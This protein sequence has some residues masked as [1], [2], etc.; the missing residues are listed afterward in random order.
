MKTDHRAMSRVPRTDR[1]GVPARRW[2]FPLAPFALAAT[3]I[4]VASSPS[5]AQSAIS[6]DGV[7]ESRA[8]GFR[9]PDGSVQTS[10]VSSGFAPVAETGQDL[11]YDPSGASGDAVPCAGTGQDGENH[12][13]VA[14][15]VQRFVVNGDGTVTDHLTGLIWLRDANCA[16]FFAPITFDQALSEAGT[17][18]EGACGLTDGSA[19]GDWRVP[20]VRELA[21]LVDYGELD[22]ALPPGHPFTQVQLDFYHASTSYRG[23]TQNTWNLYLPTG[24][25][26][27]RSKNSSTAHLWPVREGR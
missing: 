16:S 7:I 27:N 3:T 11:C 2:R 12:P 20:N 1:R 26:R 8:G 24:E 22:P 17:L 25:D 18:A 15:P 9:F 10:A 13:G 19:P 6:A 21:S 14:W 4:L 23:A 5:A